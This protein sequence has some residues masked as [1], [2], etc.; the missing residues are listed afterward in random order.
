MMIA[1]VG[2]TGFLLN[3]GITYN[4]SRQN[5]SGLN[6]IRNIYYPVLEKTVMALVALDKVAEAFN[7]AVVTADEDIIDSAS[8]HVASMQKL[9]DDIAAITPE[10]S[11]MVLKLKERLVRYESV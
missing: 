5:I 10:S 7:S 11:P 9:L 6:N 1:L 8:N 2:I 4:T 3:L